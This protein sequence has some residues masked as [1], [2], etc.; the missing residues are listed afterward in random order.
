MV[1]IGVVGSGFMAETHVEAYKNIDDADV[2]A[3]ASLEDP[4]GFID[5]SGI[6]A[7]AYDTAEELMDTEDVDAVDLCTPTPTHRPLVE[8]AAERGFDTFCEKPIA[9]N[10]KDANAIAETADEADI[11]L[12]VG[13]VVRF[14]PEYRRARDV[15]NDGGIGDPGVARARRLSPFPSWGHEDWY[16]DRDRSGGVMIDLAIHDLD[17]LSWVLG[18]VNRV[19]AQRSIWERGEHGHIVLRFDNGAVGYVEASWGLPSGQ[20]LVTSLELAGSDGLLEYSGDKNALTFRTAEDTVVENP[21]KK[22]G[23]E[24]ELEAFVESLQNGSQPPVTAEDAISALRLSL[25]ATQSA[26]SGTPIAPE[27]VNA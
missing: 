13:H 2:T 15:I 22:E 1:Q 11:K 12:M 18:D 19:Y 26:E 4:E 6:D 5:E 27:E 16:T 17:F 20:G 8:A 10:L 7:K 23:Y 21:V 14:F 9:G 3:V 24:R 25:A